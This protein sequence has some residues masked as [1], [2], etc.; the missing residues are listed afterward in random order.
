[1]EANIAKLVHIVGGILIGVVLLSLISYFFSSI[2]LLPSQED[3]TESREQLAKFNLE[4]EIY[5]KKG[6]YGVDVIS[7][8]NKAQSNN[9]KYAEGG[10]FLTGNEYGKDFYVDVYVR[11][12]KKEYLEES[13]EVYYIDKGVQR[14]LFSHVDKNSMSIIKPE[15][16]LSI[17]G[18]N[19][20]MKSVGFFKNNDSLENAYTTFSG[21][22]EIQLDKITDVKI[23]KPIG[24]I[25]SPIIK[26]KGEYSHLDFNGT[27]IK[28]YYTLRDIDKKHDKNLESL[29]MLSNKS[30]IGNLT[31]VVT[32][33]TG[34]NL[35]VWSRM[36]WKTA[37]YD[38]KSRQ[39]KCDFITY[40][41][42]TGR[43]SEIGFSE[44]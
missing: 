17:D 31:R 21:E 4:Y 7:C 37:L 34:K 22:T 2:G 42:K 36:V 14:Q 35:D 33:T 40:N 19:L 9:E 32:N 43:V 18:I 26:D 39:F 8:L 20:T 41:D 30:D 5:D 13:V 38:L 29:I 28:G 16:P 23:E 3:E 12:T 6:M 24:D 1:M 27:E 44:I 15:I 25:K 10:G 11:L